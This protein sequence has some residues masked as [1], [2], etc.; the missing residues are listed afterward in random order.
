MRLT[1]SLNLKEE[2][3]EKN[4]EH[5]IEYHTL[6]DFVSTRYEVINCWRKLQVCD[7]PRLYFPQFNL[8]DEPKIHVG[9]LVGKMGITNV[10]RVFSSKLE[11]YLSGPR[12]E[13]KMVV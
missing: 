13:G 4:V 2:R 12:K 1:L 9:Y 3:N 8:D 7:F 5:V 11:L 10:Q 6:F